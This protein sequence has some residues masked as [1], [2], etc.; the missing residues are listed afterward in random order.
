MV[1]DADRA[2]A[3]AALLSGL[4]ADDP[5]DGHERLLSALRGQPGHTARLRPARSAPAWPGT[6]RST[7]RCVPARQPGT[8]WT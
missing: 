7:R 8:A 5:L 3:H 6:W 1:D 4:G 2:L